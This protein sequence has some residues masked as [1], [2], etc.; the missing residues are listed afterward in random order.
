MTLQDLFDRLAQGE[1]TNLPMAKTGSIDPSANAKLTNYTNQ[2]LLKLYTRYILKEGDLLLQLHRHITFY[3]LLP[4]F[5]T[6]YMPTGTSDD[7][8][9]RYIWDS[10][11]EPFVDEIVKV[12]A[13]FNDCGEPIPLNDDAQPY[14]VFTPQARL[15]Q[16]PN[17]DEGKALSIHFQ[18]RHTVLQGELSDV[19]ELPD[20]LEE[21]LTSFVA[22]KAFSHMN[23]ADSNQKAQEY[24]ASFNA[25]CSE[26]VD[27]DLVNSSISQSNSRFHRG[28]WI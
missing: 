20:V 5:S 7:E 6:S 24:L 2:G 12:L 22:Y 1:L 16:V 27:R 11:T 8:L 17:P 10:P 13:V 25:I 14:S 21:A 3:H 28:G 19:I 26:V 23:S 4:R 15:L 9:V 18:Q